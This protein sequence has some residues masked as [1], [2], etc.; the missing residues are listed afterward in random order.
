MPPTTAKKDKTTPDSNS[1][2]NTPN[3]EI[4]TTTT[5]P[6]TRS[7]GP[8][9]LIEEQ[10]DVKD[11][12]DGR[13]YLEKH[14][15]LCPPGEPA[16][17]AS[18]STCLHQ[19]SIMSGVPKQAINAIR[20]V[21]FMLDEMEDTQVHESLRIALDTQMTEFTSDM[22][23]LVEDAKEKINAN[24]KAAE[25]RINN[26]TAAAPIPP[27]Q[28]RQPANSY[29]SALV[30]PPA[31]ANPRIAAKEGI[32]ARQFLMEGINNSKFSHLDNVQLKTTINNFLSDLDQ[33]SGKIRSVGKTRSG[34]IV[35]EAEND[36]TATWLS[37]ADNQ[38]K[39]CNKIGAHAEFRNR[40]YNIIAFN[41]PL[42]INPDDAEHRLEICE[43]N[44]MD[45]TTISSAKWAKAVER[46]SPQQRT[47]HLL[48]T[49][50]NVDAANR[51]IT[52]GISICNRRCHV[53][54]T[55]REPIRCL[56]CQGWNHL[57][58]DCIEERDICGNC[59]GPH[60]TNSCLTDKKRCASCKTDDHSSWSRTCPTFLRKTAEF[61]DR[62]PD[63]S[64]QYFPTADSW[65]WSAVFKTSPVGPPATT[66]K[67]RLSGNQLGKRPQQQ[68]QQMRKYDTYI[69]CDTYIPSHNYNMPENI[70]TAGWG[71]IAGPSNPQL[72]NPR[73]PTSRNSSRT[74]ASSTNN[75]A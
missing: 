14:S 22:K 67:I 42:A 30:N 43:A 2:R 7:T 71:E 12:Q 18:I 9:T 72:E 21:A 32:K 48:L 34:G 62:N 51:A 74:V 54:R 60:R 29:A 16:T 38:R 24:I 33:P 4:A 59:A 53:E 61:N 35:M 6:N 26:I 20:S 57:A 19:I 39:I 63:N 10:Q 37:S 69:P 64:L 25:E 66:P 5:K 73:P 49:L 15:L 56:K 1:N 58:K 31:H 70:D 23:M 46:R 68:Q 40:T 28:H 55:K 8:P 52:N 41:V 11:S 65:T 36:E 45:G 75:N 50:N 13:K 17:H 47:A 44:N 3:P 27:T